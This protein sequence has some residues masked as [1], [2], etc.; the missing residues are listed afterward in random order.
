MLDNMTNNLNR[1]DQGFELSKTEDYSWEGFSMNCTFVNST[2]NSK[3]SR[4]IDCSK[5][6]PPIYTVQEGRFCKTFFS[7]KVKQ[8]LI[9]KN[10]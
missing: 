9:Y 5:L 4:S 1:H 6:V 8:K 10:N 3:E 2:I 7:G